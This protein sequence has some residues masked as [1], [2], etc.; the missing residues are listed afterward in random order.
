[1][2]WYSAAFAVISKQIGR[3]V[4]AVGNKQVLLRRYLRGAMYAEQVQESFVTH[5]LLRYDWSGTLRCS[6]GTR[7]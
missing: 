4:L 5:T 3:L 2:V 1:M 7:L 6:L